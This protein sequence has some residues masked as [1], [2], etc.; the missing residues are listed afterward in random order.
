MSAAARVAM[1]PLAGMLV[2]QTKAELRAR[3]RVFGFSVTSLVLPVVLFTFFGLP[4]ARLARPDG[5][6][7]GAHVLASFGAYA[8]GQVM[9]FG[10]GIG[11]AVERGQ[12]IDLLTRTT[13]LPPAVLLMAKVLVAL[14][15]ALLSLL[16]LFGYAALVGVRVGPA[17]WGAMMV[18][19]LA[20]SLPFIALGFA[21]GY[22]AGPHAAPAVANLVYLPLAFGSGLFLPL[23]QLPD[24]VQRLAPYLPTYHYAQLAWSAVGTASEPVPVSLAW[25]LAYSVAF[26]WLALRA[27]RREERL[28]FG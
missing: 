8:V 4:F 12:R 19:L 10:F 20:G 23:R 3:W 6:S 16:V 18:R 22:T 1:A 11:V 28:R 9:V 25:L 2:A 26:G 13:P 21:I 7:E 15:F 27:Y 17:V 24:F 5:L 14:F